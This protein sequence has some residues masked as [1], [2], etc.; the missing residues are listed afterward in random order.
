MSTLD[1]LRF[2]PDKITEI[3]YTADPIVIQPYYNPREYLLQLRGYVRIP[4]KTKKVITL[5][6]WDKLGRTRRGRAIMQR[7]MTMKGKTTIE[8]MI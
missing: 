4:R 2:N 3:D 6:P 7:I 8:K 1:I 5:T